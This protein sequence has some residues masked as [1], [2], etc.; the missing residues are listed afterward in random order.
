[1]IIERQNKD[2]A[3]SS[4]Q[5]N[6]AFGEFF[7]QN[8]YTG[9]RVLVLIPDNTRSGPIGEIFKLL[10][11]HLGRRPRR[12]IA[13]SPSARTSRSPSGKSASGSP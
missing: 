8:D 11:G 12:S 7:S 13:W 2:G 3:V 6:E 9:K 5:A 4:R 1:M 10:Y